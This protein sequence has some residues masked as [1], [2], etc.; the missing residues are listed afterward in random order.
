MA[1][2]PTKTR[3]KFSDIDISDLMPDDE[4]EFDLT[5]PAKKPEPPP[6]NQDS[7][8]P[9][10]KKSNKP[11]GAINPSDQMRDYL[12]RINFDDPDEIGDDE[13][14]QRAGIAGANR[15]QNPENLP[16]VV[17]RDQVPAVLNNQLRTTGEQMPEWHT[18]NQ[19]PG[20]MA[21]NIR[22][23]GRGLFRMFTSTP[24]EDI[25]TIANV[26]G[27]G[28]NTD[29]E[30]NAVLGYLRQNGQ[31]H[32]S[33]DVSH[34]QAIPGYE[35]EVREY[36]AHGIRFHVVRDPMGKY[37]Y[38]YPESDATSR[39]A[40]PER[41]DRL[42][43]MNRPRLPRGESVMN[44][45]NAIV[46]GILSSP[47][48]VHLKERYSRLMEGILTEAST[49]DRLIGDSPGGKNLITWLHSKFGLSA[50]ATWNS[51][52][53]GKLRMQMKMFKENPDQF[54]V[55]SASQ[56]VAAIKPDEKHI[57]Q[58]KQK[59]PDYNPA[60]D[61]T[62][63]YEVVAFKKDERVDNLIV[64]ADKPNPAEFKTKIYKKGE[65]NP[66]YQQALKDWTAKHGK[67]LSPDAV[68][69]K[70]SIRGGVPGK[71]DT[72]NPNN[73]FDNLEQVL[74]RIQAIY[75]T[76]GHESAAGPMSRRE[77][78]GLT[79]RIMRRQSPQEVGAADFAG[80]EH[81]PVDPELSRVSSQGAIDR[82][83][84]AQRR[85]AGQGEP[86]VRS[87]EI[88][89]FVNKISP[90][91]MKLI[92]KTLNE[93]VDEQMVAARG[94][95]QETVGRLAKV[96]STIEKVKIQID[97]QGGFDVTQGNNPLSRIITSAVAKITGVQPGE[98]GFD[99][100]LRE[101]NRLGAAK[102]KPVLRQIKKTL[103]TPNPYGGY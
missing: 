39:G 74:G 3:T 96:I 99:Q 43:G 75:V 85:G 19:L 89:Q 50:T 79:R 35:P 26:E 32:G 70:T 91:V 6:G 31:D 61:N 25:M 78:K 49:L 68:P 84:V 13:A 58:R 80:P 27:Q 92:D 10:L 33:I 41:G 17:T 102:L 14:A 48:Q 2:K 1:T 63:K 93:L 21:R 90:I 46:E 34:G 101:I 60:G 23:M 95:D 22:G 45:K 69:T 16:D 38:A 20:Y 57:A 97:Q 76:G 100:E 8:G 37:I 4:G 52:P 98:P 67:T 86:I 55:V 7:D 64:S 12:G 81:Q 24:L 53:P 83:K 62:L 59:D 47:Y 11:V 51:H 29:E 66:E 44:K 36:T 87:A 56:G 103:M 88:Q 18:I 71:K 65:E 72:Q 73:F 40:R 82:A 42:P 9:T 15:P 54:V 5:A 28:P 94:R 30:M 77:Q